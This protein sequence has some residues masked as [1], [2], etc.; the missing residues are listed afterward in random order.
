[1]EQCIWDFARAFARADV[2]TLSYWGQAAREQRDLRP[3]STFGILEV[4][5]FKG[6]QVRRLNGKH[7]II[8][9]AR[10]HC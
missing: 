9:E 5:V 3:A 10:A 2:D 7:S 8:V 1:M 4:K 6:N